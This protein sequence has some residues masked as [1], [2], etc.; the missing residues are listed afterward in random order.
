MLEEGLRRAM[1]GTDVV[2]G[3]LDDQGRPSIDA[4]AAGLGARH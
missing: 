2:L 1:R 4:L 3:V